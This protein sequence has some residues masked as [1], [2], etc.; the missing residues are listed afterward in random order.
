LIDCDHR[1]PPPSET[2]YP[3]VTIPQLRHGRIDLT[4]VRRIT[5]EHF[6]EWTRK[7][8]PEENDVRTS[9]RHQHPAVDS[10]RE[11]IDQRN[12]RHNSRHK[13]IRVQ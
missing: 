13:E 1:T 8:L 12:L 9:M 11:A 5:P 10:V 6:V 7:A 4:N 2:G 3:Y